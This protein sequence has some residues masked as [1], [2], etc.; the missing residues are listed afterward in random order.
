[1]IG[2]E[3]EQGG[4]FDGATRR[5]GFDAIE[6]ADANARAAH[7]AKQGKPDPLAGLVERILE[8]RNIGLAFDSLVIESAAKEKAVGSP[9]FFVLRD[10]LKRAKVP[11]GEWDTCVKAVLRSDD[12]EGDD[13]TRSP[14][15]PSD[16]PVIMVGNDIHR[17][18]DESVEALSRCPSIYQRGGLGLVRIVIAPRPAQ[19]DHHAPDEG[20]PTIEP[21]PGPSL[22][23]ALSSVAQFRSYDRRVKSGD[24]TRWVKPPGDV[25]SAVGSRRPYP[26]HAIRPLMGIIEAPAL[27]PDWSIATAPGYDAATGLFLRWQGEPIDVPERP[28]HDDAKAA[29]EKLR[30]LT[31]DFVFRGDESERAMFRAA[32]V[33]MIL[34]PLARAAIDGPVPMFVLEADKESAGK[35]LL[36][37]TTGIIVTSRSLGV[38]QWSSDD[39]EAMK[40]LASI[41][42][43]A[44][45]LVLFDNIKVHVEGG[46]LEA[47][48]TAHNTLSARLLGT[49]IDRDLPWRA[50]LIAT[51]N[52]LTMSPDMNRRVIHLSMQGRGSYVGG[53][54]APTFQ[55]KDLRARARSERRAYLRAA[56][57]IF[58][59]YDLAGRPDV[60]NRP[61]ESYLAWSN[62]V[63]APLMWVSGVDPSR[64][65]PPEATDRERDIGRRVTLA[66]WNA[67]K[68]TP[69]TIASVRAD[70]EE[71]PDRPGAQSLREA[72]ADVGDVSDLKHAKPVALAKRFVR[73]V[74]GRR[75]AMHGGGFLSIRKQGENR[76]GVALFSC[77]MSEETYSDTGTVTGDGA[78]DAGDSKAVTYPHARISE[79]EEINSTPRAHDGRTRGEELETPRIPRTSEEWDF[80][81][82]TSAEL[83]LDPTNEAPDA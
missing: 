29:Y 56:Y 6:R 35:S 48:L 30:E 61:L 8:T 68:D 49:N 73:M 62:V 20:T 70:I 75:F 60:G 74:V 21:V 28:T 12:D 66:W 71:T 63:A 51:A 82:D 25:V 36:A 1:M 79:E 65:R 53:E 57:T 5:E 26:T 45:P 24:G 27:R 11:I 34:S 80:P 7:F 69:K 23:E 54:K 2:G 31:C 3:S 76:D 40:R 55:W 16:L 17:V 22:L 41:A 14:P 9:K 18:V 52:G 33:G 42:I 32:A 58:R 44:P 13:G 78:G 43:N 67:F 72:L 81:V 15:P 77:V 38:R 50:V 4:P 39:D 46:A 10:A 37:D 64:A 59:A 47:V 83:N 19:D